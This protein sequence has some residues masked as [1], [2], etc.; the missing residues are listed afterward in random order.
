MAGDQ[1]QAPCQSADAHGRR[2]R[3]GIAQAL[4]IGARARATLALG[5]VAEQ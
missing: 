1:Q 5:A 4:L 3:R 2:Q